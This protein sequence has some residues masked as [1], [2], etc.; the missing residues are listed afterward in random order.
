MKKAMIKLAIL[1]IFAIATSI[2]IYY[3]A[4]HVNRV[5]IVKDVLAEQ[6]LFESKLVKDTA[7][8]YQNPKIIV[9]PYGN[10]PL[11][12]LVIFE[13]NYLTAPSITVVGKD[14]NTTFKNTFIPNKT[15]ILPIYGLYAGTNNKVIL[16]VNNTSVTLD[17]KTEELPD[18]MILPTSI[19]ANKNELQNDLYFV[20]PSSKGYTTAYDANG[21]VRWYLKGN[22][23]WDIQRLQNGHLMLSSNRLINPPYYTTG[24]VEIDL[25]GKIYYEY[26]LPGGYHHDVFEMENGN[27]LVAT[28]NF[29][30]GTV[31]D[32]VV[33]VDRKN[34]R[35]LK[36]WDLRNIL[37]TTYGLNEYATDYDWF[38]NNSVWYDKNTNSITLSGRHQ[39]AVINIDY[40]TGE[41][42][43]IIGDP[44]GWNA[45]YLKYFFTGSYNFE[46]QYAQHAAMILPNGDIF[47]FDNGNN[48]SKIKDEYVDANHNYSRAVIY[49]INTDN[50][51]I[52]QVWQYGKELGASFYSP[53]IS[54]VDYLNKNHYLILS[55]GNSM[56]D[57]N[58]S[59]TPAGVNGADTL[60]STL[61]EVKNNK[62][63]YELTLPTN[64]YRAEK[65]NLYSD[66]SYYLSEAESIGN[67]GETK[68]DKSYRSIFHKNIDDTYKSK[69]IKI[70]KESDRLV[71]TGTFDKTDD[72][73]LILSGVFVNKTYDVRI[74]KTPYTALCVAVFDNNNQDEKITVNKYINDIGMQ[75]K[76]YIY[77][78]IN[79]KVYDP[80]LYIQY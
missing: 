7:Y 51:T 21:D 80:N 50:M 3:K 27:L 57:G 10:S 63:I 19:K 79:D 54:D 32:Y 17:I 60:N 73:K 66:N 18:D 72:V 8:T 23:L 42:N 2:I 55:G 58:Y 14:E 12:A 25:M 34:G 41:L 68:T 62:V 38:H 33:L 47:L 46:W 64:D 20:T 1:I 49:K 69:N 4:E 28:N 71:F 36:S 70:Y 5:D 6:N 43:W 61:V 11:T 40:E 76:Y 13:T 24:L 26:N 16:E 65:L 37:P 29:E 77:V 59:N 78:K 52:E 9:N 45:E 15:H 75:G 67:M 22:Y 31:E 53:Y 35:I 74:S 44:N 39:D 30:G 48:R 56:K